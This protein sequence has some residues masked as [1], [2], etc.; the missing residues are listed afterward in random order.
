MPFKSPAENATSRRGA[1]K[2]I[3]SHEKKFDASLLLAAQAG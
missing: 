3:S 2:V 1:G